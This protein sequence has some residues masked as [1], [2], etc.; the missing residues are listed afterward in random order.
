M[1]TMGFIDPDRYLGGRVQLK[2]RAVA[3][4]RSTTPSASASAGRTEE[5]AAA[6][7]DLV[8]VNM[9]NA[10]REVS[11]GKGHDPRD[12][13]FLAYGGTLPLFASQ[14]A[15]RLGIATIVIPRNSSVFCALGLLGSDFVAAHRPGRR[16][17]PVEARRGRPRQ[18][19]RRP[20]GRRRRSPGDARRGL[21]R[22]PDR[23]PAQRRHPLPGPGVRAHAADAR[24]AADRRRRA[25]SCSTSSSTLYERTYGEGTAWKG[26]PAS[27]I[28]YSVTVIGRQPRPDMDQ[29]PSAAGQA[30]GRSSASGARVFLP[31]RAPAR[32]DPDL[33]RRALHRRD[34]R[35]RARR[36]STPT[37]TTIYVPPGTTAER[38]EYMNYVLTR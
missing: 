16:L 15:E 36:S 25:R 31:G 3:R 9:A 6:V 14:I 10:V 8:V 11:V 19:D 35:S 7:H 30:G 12:F 29:T 1:V 20:D 21:R 13:L 4:R 37:D 5:A 33:R 38:D 28:N 27:M 34:R 18:R 17:G 26:V 24:P 23:D 2:P 22:R 32:G